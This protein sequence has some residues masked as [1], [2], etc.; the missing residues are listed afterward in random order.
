MTPF[1]HSSQSTKVI[2]RAKFG[3]QTVQFRCG[4][5][6]IETAQEAMKLIETHLLTNLR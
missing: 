3:L 1:S 6:P 5:Y 4:G 2:G